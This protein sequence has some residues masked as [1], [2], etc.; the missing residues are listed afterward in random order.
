MDEV[1]EMGP[2]ALSDSGL[3]LSTLSITSIVAH[4]DGQRRV[5]GDSK[6][7]FSAMARKNS[8]SETTELWS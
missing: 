7:C 1:D 4:S 2:S 6:P 8:D 3:L 5:C